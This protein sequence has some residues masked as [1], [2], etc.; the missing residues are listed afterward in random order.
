MMLD[1]LND[2]HQ[3]VKVEALIDLDRFEPLLDQIAAMP[4]LMI[5]FFQVNSIGLNGR[6]GTKYRGVHH[7]STYHDK[8][9][10]EVWLEPGNL[11]DLLQKISTAKQE[12]I[13]VSI[14][15]VKDVHVVSGNKAE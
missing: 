5:D 8:M 15:E 3:M 2:P 6:K 13:P 4:L 9:K 12:V 10:L 1:F 7:V 14:S 11:D